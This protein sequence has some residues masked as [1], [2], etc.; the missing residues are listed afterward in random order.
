MGS[1]ARIRQPKLPLADWRVTELAEGRS[2]TWVTRS[3]GVRVTAR[4][5]VDPQ[6][7]ESRATLCLSFAGLLGPLVGWL[8]RALNERYL[9]LEADGLKQR[10]EERQ[11][12]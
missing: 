6:A 1:R 2:F 8:T 12:A 10:S 9:R 5:W 4:H 7:G 3:P 11:R